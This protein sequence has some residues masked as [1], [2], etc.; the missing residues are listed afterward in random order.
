MRLPKGGN[1][2]IFLAFKLTS[3]PEDI[4]QYKA[5]DKKGEATSAKS[6]KN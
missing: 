5:D 6:T 2:V 3:K 4:K 1:H